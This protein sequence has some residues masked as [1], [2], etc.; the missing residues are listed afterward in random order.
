MVV[1]AVD[2]DRWPYTIVETRRDDVTARFFQVLGG[3]QG[4]YVEVGGNGLPWRAVVRISSAAREGWVELPKD[5]GYWIP[6]AFVRSD[7]VL[8]PDEATALGIAW[9]Q[10]RSPEGEWATR[11]PRALR[12]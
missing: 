2:G 8:T 4:C 1:G 12:P 5:C 6:K 11:R 7:E 3:L 10:G 9:L